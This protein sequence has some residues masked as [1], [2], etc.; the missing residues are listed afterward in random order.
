[1]LQMREA[2]PMTQAELF[3]PDGGPAFACTGK[4]VAT[5]WRARGPSVMPAQF[6]SLNRR[7]TNSIQLLT[8]PDENAACQGWV[9][10]ENGSMPRLMIT[11]FPFSTCRD[12]SASCPQGQTLAGV[13]NGFLFAPADTHGAGKIR[14]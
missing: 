8:G 10:V 11:S 6:Y 12:F 13:L 1:M 5:M 7:N 14:G 2:N 9:D 3:R 4:L